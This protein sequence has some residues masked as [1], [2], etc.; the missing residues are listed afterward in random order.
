MK[1]ITEKLDNVNQLEKS[2]SEIDTV[3]E[4]LELEEDI[5]LEKDLENRLN[6]VEQK[7]E[8]F[9]IDTLL[10]GKYDSYNAI[11]TLHSGAGGTEAQDWTQMLFRMYTM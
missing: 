4:L 2:L 5:S 7:L 6:E 3:I 11:M 10:N 1:S 9:K 8:D